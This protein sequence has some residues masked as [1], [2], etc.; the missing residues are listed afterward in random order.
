MGSYGGQLL[1]VHNIILDLTAVGSMLVK[2]LCIY[3]II[4]KTPKYMKTVSY[5]FLNE[6]LWNIAAHV[7]TSLC[8]GS[9]F[10]LWW[11]PVSEYPRNELPDDI[12]NLFCFHPNGF[13]MYLFEFAYLGWFAF[14]T[15]FIALLAYLCIRY[16][17]KRKHLMQEKTLIIHRE[18]L[19]NLV[20]ITSM[21][22]FSGGILLVLI[23]FFL[24]N[25]KSTFAR[26]VT[27]G[28]M[29]SVLNYGTLYSIL[30]MSLFK[31][32]RKA[33]VN[34]AKSWRNAIKALTH[35]FINSSSNV[36]FQHVNNIRN[37]KF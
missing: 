10:Y 30:L 34:I 14:G 8:S 36:V 22:V 29:L 12:D 23:V 3:I 4:K 26:E 18:I 13:P 20:I 31:P 28:L 25:G 6:L 9:V 24:C 15:C 1:Y 19:K 27:Y 5:F 2:P 21:A 7:I 11:L 33:A 16:L 35:P 17:N 32:Y 37:V